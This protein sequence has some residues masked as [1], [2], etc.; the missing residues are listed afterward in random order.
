MTEEPKKKAA[1]RKRKPKAPAKVHSPMRELL[2]NTCAQTV[3][4]L[5]ATM[6][7]EA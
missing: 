2:L 6:A 4:M 1:P 5:H 7:G 3:L